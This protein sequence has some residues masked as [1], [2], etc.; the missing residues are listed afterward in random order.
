MTQPFD[1]LIHDTCVLTMTGNGGAQV[2]E[3][4]DLCILGPRIAAIETTRA[5]SAGRARDI[6]PGAGRVAMPGL[7]NTHSHVPMVL[8]RG[9]A[10]DVNL[11]RWFNDYMWPLERNLQEE[12][13]YWGMMLGL[14]EMIEAG[15]TS[16]AD[17]YFFMDRAAEAVAEAGTR[18]ALGWAIFGSQGEA[19]IDR[20]SQFIQ[21]WQGAADGRITTWMA[22]HA[23]YTCDDAFLRSC[24]ECARDL[25]VGI[26]MHVAETREQTGKCLVERGMTPIQLLDRLGVLSLPVILAHAVG[27]TEEDI[28]L[29]A[30]RRAGIAHCPKTYLK[31]AM[32]IA[33]VLDFLRAGVAVG[34]ATD[35]AVSNNTLDVWESMRLMAMLQKQHSSAPENMTVENTLHL[36]SRM[37][38]QVIGLGDAIGALEPGRL[39]DIIL[40]DVTGTHT[41]PLHNLPATL[42]YATRAS[43]VQTVI[44]NGK[45]LMRDR[46]LLTIDKPLVMKKVGERMARLSQRVPQARIQVYAP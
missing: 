24:A 19:A 15:V 16:V 32:G 41:Q 27:A 31:L 17:H 37:S 43:D 25:D 13:V 4:H 39:A 14:A 21:R 30:D 5:V 44:V 6:I 40:V 20:T 23:P 36:A 29:L 18:A 22:P 26:H 10:E 35:G 46:K 33:P 34:L 3:H 28:R 7:I 8:F 9:L 38:A 2:L 11:E 12:D 45:I 1:L 42:V